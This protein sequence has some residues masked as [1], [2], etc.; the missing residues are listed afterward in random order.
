MKPLRTIRYW[1]W[2][3]LSNEIPLLKGIASAILLKIIGGELRKHSVERLV[4]YDIGA[5]WGIWK[6]FLNLPLPLYKVG[7]EP[8]TQEAARLEASRAF[9]RVC[10]VGL[11]GENGSRT[12]YFANDPGSSS[13]YG[14]DLAEIRKHC[15]TRIFEVQ[16]EIPIET[17]TLQSAIERWKLPPPDFIKADVEGA[18]LEI[19]RSD[20]EA[21]GNCAGVFVETRLRSFY[22]GEPNFGDYSDFFFKKNF[23]TIAF[24]P[25][26]SFGG[27]IMLVD[28]GFAKN[29]RQT[30]DPATL[31]KTAAF[32]AVLGNNRYAL[33]CLQQARKS[34]GAATRQ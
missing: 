22:R 9:D 28:V 14:P 24:R 12:L 1:T 2:V 15:D 6:P 20:V 4:V 11:S 18:E 25:V 13:I 3:L 16:R 32:A 17:I 29:C 27:A 31:L 33:S 34:G 21:V 26:G 30:T 19:F 23:S 7:F 5:R 8:D 10:P